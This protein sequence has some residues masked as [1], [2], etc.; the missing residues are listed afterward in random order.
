MTLLDRFTIRDTLLTD[1]PSNEEKQ[2]IDR[3]IHAIRVGRIQI[4]N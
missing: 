2:A 3:L 1:Q 4:L